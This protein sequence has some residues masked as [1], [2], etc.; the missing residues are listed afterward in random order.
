MMKVGD[1]V[2][3][4]NGAVWSPGFLIHSLFWG[5]DDDDDDDVPK[6]RGVV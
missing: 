1:L 3:R 4:M 5:D 2:G 6:V